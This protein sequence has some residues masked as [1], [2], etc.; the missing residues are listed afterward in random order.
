MQHAREVYSQESG[1]LRS[2]G[3]VD[4]K[5]IDLLFGL[6]VRPV[7][8]E[9]FA[10]GPRPQ[11]PR[12]AGRGEAANENPD[13]GRHHLVVERVGIAGHRFVPLRTGGSRRGGE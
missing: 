10:I 13:A 2:V 1:I 7:G 11:R 8:D 12:G 9:H 6:Q 5:K 4:F 3:D